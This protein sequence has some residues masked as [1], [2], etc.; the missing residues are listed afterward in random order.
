MLPLAHMIHASADNTLMRINCMFF[1]GVM[2]EMVLSNFR[3]TN[4]DDS[5]FLFEF[6]RRIPRLNSLH[7]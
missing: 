1:G 6:D 4:G 2:I 3:T 5:T 7:E